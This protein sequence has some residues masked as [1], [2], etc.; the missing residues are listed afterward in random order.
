MKRKSLI[1]A[2]LLIIFVTGCDSYIELNDLVIINAI[3]ITKTENDYNL[4]LS[5]VEPDE[6]T[7]MEPK[8]TL[9]IATGSSI[10][11]IIDNLSLTLNK[12]IYLSHLNLLLIDDT[13]KKNEWEEIVNFFLNNNETREDYLVVN[14]NNIKEA[15]E[16]T[17]FGF[18][19]E[20]IENNFNE[21]SKTIKTT[22][23]DVIEKIFNHEKLYLPYLE[24]NDSI[25]LNGLKSYYD[26][27]YLKINSED[28]IY[29]NYYLNNI[30]TYKFSY[31]C[32]DNNKFLYLNILKAYTKELKNE[33]VITN[34]LKIINNDCNFSK[35]EIDKILSDNLKTNIKKISNKKIKIKNIVRGLYE[36]K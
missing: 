7:L 32:L 5:L 36:N 20:L 18:I 3:G 2:I 15:L 14:T 35:S 29:L 21:T 10:N 23:Y 13:I 24:I 26:N 19:N 4:Y 22:M 34:E 27:N 28:V 12:K 16:K 33:I 1:L 30:K 9:Q 6:N 31:K 17:K 25:K 11:Q 8:T